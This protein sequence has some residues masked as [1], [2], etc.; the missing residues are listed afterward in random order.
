MIFAHNLAFCA[1]LVS[2]AVI[3]VVRSVEI[4]VVVG[5]IGVLAFTPNNVVCTIFLCVS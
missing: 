4:P 5:G 3:P 2:L 1:A